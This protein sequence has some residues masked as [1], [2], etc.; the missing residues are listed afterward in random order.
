MDRWFGLVMD[1]MV[2]PYFER[3][4]ETLKQRVETPQ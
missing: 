4:L 3:V 2:G 1:G